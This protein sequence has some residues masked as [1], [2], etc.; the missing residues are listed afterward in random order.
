MSFSILEYRFVNQRRWSMCL[1][2]Q[3]DPVFAQEALQ[4][5]LGAR[6]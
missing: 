1:A 4:K 6:T 5:L 2:A 3:N